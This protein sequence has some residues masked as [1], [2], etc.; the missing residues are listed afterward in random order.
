MLERGQPSAAAAGWERIWGEGLTFDDV[1]LIPQR[2]EIIPSQARVDASLGPLRLEIP[3]LSAAMDTVTDA[4]LA[5]ALARLGGLGILHR[6]WTVEEQADQ[7]A[8]VAQQGLAV[9]G[10][11]GV[12]PD[13]ERR[14]RALAEA[15]ASCIVIDTAHGHSSRVLDTVKRLKDGLPPEVPVVAGNVVTAEATLD[16]IS[17]GADAV[18][19]G[20]GP[21]S[22]CTTRVVSG[23]G[24]PQLTAI[25]QCAEAAAEAGVAV[26]ADGGMK[27]SGDMVKALAAGAW[28][29]MLGNPL[30]GVEEAPGETVEVEGRLYKRY[31]G[32]GSREAMEARRGGEV[33]DRYGQEDVQNP[34]K[35][36]PEG[37]AGLVPARGPLSDVVAELVGGIKSGMGYVG[38]SDLS[39]LRRRTRF[40]RVTS[41]GRQ[42][43]RPGS[44]RL[45]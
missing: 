3:I 38:A 19:V 13:G 1:L 11:V 32:M 21:G 12:G 43:S 22:V 2:S 36:V 45:Q 26:L 35:L 20:V 25:M 5:A 14:A 10:A 37:V 28:L 44:V 15:G 7:A 23:A 17:A 30:A 4:R 6:N 34:A 42:E 24:F 16:L 29:L 40:V 8:Q 27:T 39:D 33:R 9:G 31:R 18:K 41:A